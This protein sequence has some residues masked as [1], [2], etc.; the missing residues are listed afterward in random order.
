MPTYRHGR[1]EHGQNFLHDKTIQKNIVERVQATTGPI[2]EIGPGAGALTKPLAS[3]ERPLTAVEID[4]RLARSLDQQLHA[5]VEVVHCDF[6]HH[7]LPET[8]HVLV[9]NLPFH[10]TTAMLR[11]ILRAPG[12]THAVLIVQWEVARRRAGVGGATLM[13]A[14]W[15]PWFTFELGQRVPARA[16]TP[17]PSVDGGVLTITR[18]ATPLLSRRERK[19]Y[20]AM[21]H[22]VFTGRGRGIVEI[23]TR[24]GLFDRARDARKWSTA[25]GLDPS[26]LPKDLSARQWADLYRTSGSSP[27][28]HRR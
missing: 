12:W 11:H 28:K 13:T 2:I 27:P 1:H 7:R 6:L 23:A 10:Q 22:Q 25:S 18:R 8:A 17:A 5:R 9:G 4:S 16:F 15:S 19:A 3:L 26:A 14:Q 21:A 24:A 20:Q